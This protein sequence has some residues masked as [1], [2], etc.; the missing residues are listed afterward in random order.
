MASKEIVDFVQAFNELWL[1]DPNRQA[2]PSPLPHFSLLDKQNILTFQDIDELDE[3]D[4]K[5]MGFLIGDRKWFMR[6]RYSIIQ[7]WKAKPHSKLKPTEMPQ[8]V[9]L[10]ASVPQGVYAV[11]MDAFGNRVG[12]LVCPADNKANSSSNTSIPDGFYAAD[13][14]LLW[15]ARSIPHEFDD[16]PSTKPS[17]AYQHALKEVEEAMTANKEK[18]EKQKGQLSG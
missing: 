18:C 17:S 16:W 6:H 12:T 10:S 9:P 11:T 13:G 8:I 4:L 5:E 14:T 2:R 3:H 15:A 1:Q 7:R